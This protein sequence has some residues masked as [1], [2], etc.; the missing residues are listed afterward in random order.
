MFCDASPIWPFLQSLA[1]IEDPETS[2]TAQVGVYAIEKWSGIPVGV[3]LSHEFRY[4]EPAIN[5]NTLVVSVSQS[6]ETMDTLMAVR[7]AA[8]QGAKTLS[9]CNTQGATIP[10][11]SGAALY[12]HAGPEVAVASTKAFLAQVVACYLLGMYL[13]H[14]SQQTL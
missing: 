12:T 6:G 4:R 3:E 5:E 8:E 7:Y 2:R 11:E 1:A 10:R 14:T 13:G 9:I